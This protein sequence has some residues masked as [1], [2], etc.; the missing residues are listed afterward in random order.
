MSGGYMS[1]SYQYQLLPNL[2]AD[3]YA[4]LKADIAERGVLVA[5]EY[6]EAGHILDGH[7]RVKAAHELGLAEWPSVV[8]GGMTEQE[9]RQH[10]WALNLQRRHLSKEQ[11]REQWAAMRADGMTHQA[12]ADVSGVNESTVRRAVSA[13]AETQPAVI[14]GKDGKR[15]P[16]QRHKA[17][18]VQ[19]AEQAMAAT[20]FS[21][22]SLEYYTPAEYLQAAREVMGG[23]DLDPATCE[24]A[25]AN[26][27]AAK[28]YTKED[29]GFSLPWSGRVWLNPPYSKTN[30][31]SNQEMW[32]SHLTTE[33]ESRNVDEAILLVKSALGYKWYEELW[34][35]RW[36][37]LA[38]ERLSFIMESGSD[39]GQSKQGTTFVYFGE[40]AEPFCRVFAQ[41][42]R[43]IPPEK[44]I[45]DLLGF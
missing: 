43:I 11:W 28:F 35:E 12:I 16:A 14:V 22:K 33:Y 15:Y 34:R 40:E 5:V 32:A 21:H 41:F 23:I 29:D 8:R 2:T 30:G 13:N 19:R 25:Q 1:E 9:K 36:V 37:C 18:D 42:G 38:R 10:V 4:S 26:V 20:M 17:P 24:A 45:H 39:D 3:E 27:K 31:R 6:D 44:V 7:H